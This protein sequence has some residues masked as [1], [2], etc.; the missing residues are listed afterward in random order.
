[1]NN[2]LKQFAI[3]ILL[4]NVSHIFNLITD[5]M[6]PYTNVVIFGLPDYYIVAFDLWL[7]ISS[8]IC[9]HMVEWHKL[10]HVLRQFRL[11]QDIL[12]QCDKELRLH[13]YDLRGQHDLDWMN[14]HHHYIWRWEARYN[15]LGRAEVAS[16]SF[17]YN[18]P[19]MVWYHSITR[20]FVTPHGSL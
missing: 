7:T 13:K 14:I 6:E 3:K 11:L 4:N 20:F 19:Y 1:M 17:G 12:E 8:L 10:D 16:T 15:N 9:F 5:Y 18:H 2:F